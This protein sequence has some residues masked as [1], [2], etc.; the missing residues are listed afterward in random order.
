MQKLFIIFAGIFGLFGNALGAFGAHALKAK[1]T[2]AML[3]VYQT[4][5]QYQ[6]YH[7][8]SL[9]LV[10]VLLFHIHSS[11]LHLSGLA[12]IAGVVLFSGSLFLLSITGITW[13][14]VITPI[15]GLSFILGW[16]FLI[17]AVIQFKG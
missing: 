5:V 10:A 2:P 11:W 15:G 12:F 4:G 17:I 3:A 1:L 7:A 6:F 8:L 9:L 13:I 14:G 16:I